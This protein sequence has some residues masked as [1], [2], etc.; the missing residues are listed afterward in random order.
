[1][2]LRLLTAALMLALTLT[3]PPAPGCADDAQPV[4]DPAQ[5]YQARKMNPEPSTR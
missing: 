3:L 1:M 2:S 5:P 4:L